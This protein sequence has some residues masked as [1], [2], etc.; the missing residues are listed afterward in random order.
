MSI[1]D[2]KIY[3]AC[4]RENYHRCSPSNNYYSF[5]ISSGGFFGRCLDAAIRMP[6][7][8]IRY[9]CGLWVQSGSQGY[10]RVYTPPVALCCSN[11]A[12]PGIRVRLIVI[13]RLV[14]LPWNRLNYNW[15]RSI[16]STL[17]VS[18]IYITVFDQSIKRCSFESTSGPRGN[19]AHLLI[20]S[21]N[22][23][24]RYLRA[25]WRNYAARMKQ[26]R[27]M[28]NFSH[29]ISSVRRDS[30]SKPFK[31]L[32]SLNFIKLQGQFCIV[33]TSLRRVHS[34]NKI[35]QVNNCFIFLNQRIEW[36]EFWSHANIFRVMRI[37][38][39]KRAL[40]V[41][42]QSCSLAHRWIFVRL[43]RR[44]PERAVETAFITRFVDPARRIATRLLVRRNAV[45]P[46]H[47]A[48]TK[49]T[50]CPSRKS[51]SGRAPGGR[52]RARSAQ[53]SSTLSTDCTRHLGFQPHYSAVPSTLT[54]VE[55]WPSIR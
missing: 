22:L 29:C 49:Y 41:H 54:V 37:R 4:Y 9:A 33:R 46:G 23:F 8:E 26:T 12:E 20:I 5:L 14:P 1:R 30:D 51:V 24:H 55:A 50:T 3:I 13:R 17:I 2:G 10:P 28:D 21:I 18:T 47:G 27:R 42:W 40:K 53:F 34:E 39:T 6:R 31:Y 43:E 36:Y 16:R 44:G 45:G 15:I 52:K 32:T 7:C 11:S 35:L 19:L 38:V 48:A 25:I